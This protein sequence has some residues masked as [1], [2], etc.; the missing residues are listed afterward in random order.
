MIFTVGSGSGVATGGNQ[1]LPA[2]VT[3]GNRQQH[4]MGP[5]WSEAEASS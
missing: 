4:M 1:P 2:A 3:E 5:R